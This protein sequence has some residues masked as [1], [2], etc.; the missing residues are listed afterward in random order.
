MKTL[1]DRLRMSKAEIAGDPPLM[2]NDGRDGWMSL[3]NCWLDAVATPKRRLWNR[4]VTPKAD[5]LR[6]RLRWIEL[7]D[8]H[9]RLKALRAT[10]GDG[11]AHG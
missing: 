10:S 4:K 11:V 3:L 6:D 1:V 8:E 5:R 2:S 7:T 9:C